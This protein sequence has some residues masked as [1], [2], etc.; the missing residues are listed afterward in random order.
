MHKNSGKVQLMQKEN[1]ELSQ[2]IKDA[3]LA[4]YFETGTADNA[5]LITGLGELAATKLMSTPWFEKELK[6]LKR[7]KDR[8]LDGSITNMLTKTL[9]ALADRIDNG[10][11]KVVVT[12]EGVIR[13]NQQMSGKDLAIVTGV[14]FDKRA[15]LRREPEQDDMAASALDRIAEKLR[16]YTITEKLQGKQEVVDVEAKTTAG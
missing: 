5:R 3:F 15:Q 12:K 7:R 16:Q 4:A 14:L 6:E 1:A 13:A 2:D 8:Q 11:E 9:A 10:D